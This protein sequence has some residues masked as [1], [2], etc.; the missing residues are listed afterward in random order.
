[1]NVAEELLG[2]KSLT[3]AHFVIYFVRAQALS[4]VGHHEA[5]AKDMSMLFEMAHCMGTAL[6]L[7]DCLL[8]EAQLAESR[9]DHRAALSA[10]REGLALAADV[11]LCYF[12]VWRPAT[13]A[14]LMALALENDI[15]PEAACTIIRERK[16]APPQPL[17][18]LDRW[19]RRYR[20]QMLGQFA[21]MRDGVCIGRA[22]SAKLALLQSLIWH[23]GRNISIDQVADDL[24]PDKDGDRAENTLRV[25]ILR[26]RELLGEKGAISV[27]HRTISLDPSLWWSDL[28]EYLLI[29]SGDALWTR[30]ARKK[31]RDAF[32][33][34]LN[35]LRSFW[36]RA[37]ESEI[38]DRCRRRALTAQA[39]CE[40]P[41]SPAPL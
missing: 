20:A 40:Q 14:R 19:P 25:T 39:D 24:W 22:P 35:H 11:P 15:E 7:H 23:G 34:A 18:P 26:L 8:A 36:E 2:G 9:G 29:G 5:A 1:M 41:G 37:G 16:L 13:L 27:A 4:E 10:L 33:R 17:Q 38:A 31:T 12:H 21:P 32:I 3:L 30:S 6:Q 28:D